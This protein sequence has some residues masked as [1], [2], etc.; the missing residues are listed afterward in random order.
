[1]SRYPRSVRSAR[2][3][4]ISCNAPAVDTIDNGYV[5]VECG[6]SPANTYHANDR[7]TTVEPRLVGQTK[8]GSETIESNPKTD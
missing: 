5:C 3:K 8:A 2:V 7:A 1:M 6:D 4:C